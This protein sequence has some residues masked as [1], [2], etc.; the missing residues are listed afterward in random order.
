[1][2]RATKDLPFLRQVARQLG[3]SM[4]AAREIVQGIGTVIDRMVL[5][6]QEVVWPKLGRFY[7][8]VRKPYEING[9]V[10][11]QRHQIG[12]SWQLRFQSRPSGWRQI[13]DS[14]DPKDSPRDP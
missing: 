12:A 3:V 8:A 6:D 9:L 13:K 2:P 7:R 4:S 11:G 14:S 10:P 5:A 1:M